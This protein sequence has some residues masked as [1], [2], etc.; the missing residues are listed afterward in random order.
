M[1]VDLPA[2]HSTLRDGLTL[3]LEEQAGGLPSYA[4]RA[5]EGKNYLQEGKQLVGMDG[6]EPSTPAL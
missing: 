5:S 4:L 6:L 3:R 1:G 2:C